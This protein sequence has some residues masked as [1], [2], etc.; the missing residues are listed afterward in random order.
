MSQRV[1]DA[2]LESIAADPSNSKFTRDVYAELL[3]ARKVL[4]K[5][6]HF[7]EKPTIF[8]HRQPFREALE[9]HNAQFPEEE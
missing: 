1:S 2:V 5:G 7:L 6:G 4:K 8:L 9:A 3:S